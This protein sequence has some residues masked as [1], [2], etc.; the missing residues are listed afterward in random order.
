MK[1]ARCGETIRSRA[2]S[3]GHREVFGP[4]CL[5]RYFDRVRLRS[6]SSMEDP[7]GFIR[8]DVCGVDV[9]FSGSSAKVCATNTR[10]C[11]HCPRFTVESTGEFCPLERSR[12]RV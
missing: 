5:I 12:G 8:C 4:K 2:L 10:C 11:V 7:V 1:C 3:E 9:M 6:E